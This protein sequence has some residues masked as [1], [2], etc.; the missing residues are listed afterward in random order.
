MLPF[1]GAIAHMA[2]IVAA[3]LMAASQWQ[4]HCE[5]ETLP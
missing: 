2:A 5:R 3:L 4:A 1:L